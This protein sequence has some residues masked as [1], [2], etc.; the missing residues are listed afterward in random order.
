MLAAQMRARVRVRVVEQHRDLV[1]RKAELPV[2]QDP[3]EP[4]EVGVGVAAV[5][6]MGAPAGRQEAD[7]VVVVQGAHRD[8][9]EPRDLSHGVAQLPTPFRSSVGTTVSLRP[10]VT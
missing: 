9:G 4:V 2:E 3:L 5:T 6:R 10:H 8:T 1:E 7:L